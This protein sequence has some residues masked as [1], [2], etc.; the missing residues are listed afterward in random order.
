MFMSSFNMIIPELPTFLTALGGEQ[1]LGLNISL[2]TLMA[3]ISRPFSGR[4]VDTIGRIPVMIVGALM[5]SICGLFYPFVTS[6]LAYFILRTVHGMS[7]GFKPTGT[8]AFL[9]DVVPASRR[10]EALGYLGMS[11]SLGM[12]SGPAIG[13]WVALQFGQ[14]AMFYLSSFTALLSIVVLLGMKETLPNPQR[15]RLGLLKVNRHQVY[16]PR[17]LG[18]TIVMA[19]LCVAFGT[20]LTITPDLSDH[21]GL[22]NRGSYMTVFVVCSL[23]MRI[24]AG[25]ASDRYGRKP[26]LQIGILFLI[27]GMLITGLATN[28]WVFLTGAAI[29]G[30]S[31]GINAPTLFAWA[32]DLSLEAERGKAMSTLYI[33]LEA[34]IGLGALVSAYIYNNNTAMFMPTF[35]ACAGTAVLALLYVLSLRKLPGSFGL[36]ADA[37]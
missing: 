26:V 11:G 13:G 10:G 30:M 20:V 12:A 28:D 1:Y 2:F 24:L 3:L 14:E 31:V 33:G 27:A 32:V 36:P 4:L 9:A 25:R 29:Y 37:Q 8:T 35:W 19:L 17:V 15:F 5:S 6:V 18:I 21:V 22:T 16:E 23:M 7:T 34:G